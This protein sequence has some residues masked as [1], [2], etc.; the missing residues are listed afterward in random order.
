[1]ALVYLSLQEEFLRIFITMKNMHKNGDAFMAQECATAIMKYILSGTV[2]TTDSGSGSAGGSYV[3]HGTGTMSINSTLLS[4]KLLST[5]NAKCN[6]VE[7]ARNMASDINSVCTMS[8]TVSTVSVGESTTGSSVYP[9]GGNGSGNFS[10]QENIIFLNLKS[11]F[12]AMRNIH[13][14]QGDMFFAQEFAKAVDSYLK[15]GKITITRIPPLVAT[16]IGSIS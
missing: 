4:N 13:N 5:F 14:G 2:S 10:S 12:D 11:C 8:G 1:M 16:G 15:S 6:E 7:L 9:D 3:G